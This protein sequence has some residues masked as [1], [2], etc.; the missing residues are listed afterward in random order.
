MSKEISKHH[1]E[2]DQ[3]LQ[4]SKKVRGESF[5]VFMQLIDAKV[6]VLKEKLIN[7]AG[8]TVVSSQIAG[9]I[10]HLRKLKSE[11]L[12]KPVELKK[13]GNPTYK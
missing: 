4:R 2:Y 7:A 10:K 9:G 1:D 3:L 11:I 6:E 8:D 12:A 13:T 5:D